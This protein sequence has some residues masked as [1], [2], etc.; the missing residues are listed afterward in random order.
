METLTPVDI[1]AGI[2]VGNALFF[3]FA[4]GLWL[5]RKDDD[6]FRLWHVCLFLP[7]FGLMFYHH[8]MEPSL[9]PITFAWAA[10]TSLG[11]LGL[12]SWLIWKIRYNRSG[13]GVWQYFFLLFPVMTAAIVFY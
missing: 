1:A 11:L 13:L 9:G 4:A 5:N 6:D 10:F 2:F 12:T 7:G 8:Y 3:L